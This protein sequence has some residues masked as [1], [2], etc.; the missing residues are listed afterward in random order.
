MHIRIFIHAFQAFLGRLKKSEKKSLSR[1]DSVIWPSYNRFQTICC[2]L[3]GQP[4]TGY[5]GRVKG[6]LRYTPATTKTY[7]PLSL[8]LW[9][10]ALLAPAS[11]HGS[12]AYDIATIIGSLVSLGVGATQSETVEAS[13]SVL[14]YK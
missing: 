6:D 4:Y 3:G 1:V 8:L 13:D 7:F 11:M 5:S 14:M 12:A 10:I 2:R 9:G